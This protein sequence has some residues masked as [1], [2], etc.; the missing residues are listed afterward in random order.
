[1]PYTH[2]SLSALERVL[3]RGRLPVVMVDADEL[4]AWHRSDPYDGTPRDS[5]ANH[6]VVVTGVDAV[7]NLVYLNDSA[8]QS[9]RAETLTVAQFLNAWDDALY[10]AC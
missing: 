1:M 6:A 9:G 5:G 8:L 3:D 4:P 7:H 2:A 10:D